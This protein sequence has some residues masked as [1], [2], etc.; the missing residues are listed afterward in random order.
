MQTGR[1]VT[2]LPFLQR[3]ASEKYVCSIL[4]IKNCNLNPIACP[5]LNNNSLFKIR[6]S[7]FECN[8]YLVVQ[9]EFQMKAARLKKM[10]VKEMQVS[11]PNRFE[12]KMN[13]I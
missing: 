4:R 6:Q 8:K 5:F 9:S 10:L 2:K 7:F 12:S 11:I 3:P 13:R 1:G